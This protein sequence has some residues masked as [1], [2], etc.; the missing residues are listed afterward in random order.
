MLRGQFLRGE[1]SLGLL[2]WGRRRHFL[3]APGITHQ[4]HQP[5]HRHVQKR[6]RIALVDLHRRIHTPARL[7]AIR[8]EPVG[9]VIEVPPQ[10]VVR[11]QRNRLRRF[12]FA[13]P[14]FF[15]VD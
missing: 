15:A 5:P 10:N 6:H 11:R 4:E 9:G 12:Q 14:L 3:D 1:L 2:R 7:K 13:Y 8:H